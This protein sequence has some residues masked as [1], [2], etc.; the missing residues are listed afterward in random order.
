MLDKEDTINNKMNKFNKIHDKIKY[1]AFGKVTIGKKYRKKEEDV[2]NIISSTKEL[3]EEE[4]KRV[5]EEINEIKTMKKS[6]VGKICEIRRRV[7]GGKKNKIEQTAIVDPMTGRVVGSRKKVKEVT[8]KYCKDTLKKNNTPEGY[9]DMFFNKKREV[10]RKL[11]ECDGKFKPQKEAFVELINK[12]KRGRKRNYDFLVRSSKRFQDAVFRFTSEMFE[13]EEF[14]D[15]F[16]ET[17]LHMIFKGGKGKRHNLNDNRFIHSKFWFARAAEGLVVLEGLKGPLLE[18]SSKYQVGGQPGHRSE[19]LVFALKSV[20]S[21]YRKE[22]KVLIIQTYD[23]SKFFDKEQLEDA[24]LTCYNRGADPKACRL[25]YKLNEDTQIRVRTGAGLTEYS[26]AGS[27]VGQ[28][29]L[30]GA[31]VSQGVLDQGISEHFTPGGGDEMT[32]G[33]VPLAPFIFMDDIIYGAEG[34]KSARI[35]NEKIDKVVKSLNLRLNEDKTSYIL[36][37][38]KKQTSDIRRELKD[39]ERLPA[40]YLETR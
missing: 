9:E 14:P 39:K 4:V 15:C 32:Y 20:I 2:S 26:G 38:S 40:D 17:T 36:I 5:E 30:G 7:I 16:K 35:A 19:E 22:G 24:I 33:K 21:R 27:L 34:I 18:G 31:L 23:I 11:R 12:F 28:G 13:K 3:F 8:L 37:G 29:T 1:K 25:W 10:E 6:R